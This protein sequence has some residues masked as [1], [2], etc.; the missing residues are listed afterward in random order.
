MDRLAHST[1]AGDAAPSPE[2]NGLR[3]SADERADAVR[4]LGD[5]YAAGRLLTAE[6]EE[7]VTA[8]YGARVVADLR[9]SFE[10]LPAPHPAWVR[11]DQPAPAAHHGVAGL[12]GVRFGGGRP[13]NA[14][15]RV[16]LVMLGLGVIWLLTAG[17]ADPEGCLARIVG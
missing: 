13:P 1:H 7:R 11:P 3:I 4:L 14:V 2:D 12:L 15:A 6:Y 8:V 5:H 16:V 9:S 10:D 17:G